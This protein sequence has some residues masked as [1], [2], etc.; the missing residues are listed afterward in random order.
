VEEEPEA[1][2]SSQTAGGAHR[3]S[4]GRRRPSVR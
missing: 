3:G 2:D 1:V 4:E